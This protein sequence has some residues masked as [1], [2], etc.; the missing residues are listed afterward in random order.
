MR[1]T[2]FPKFGKDLEDLDNYP[3]RLNKVVIKDYE[4]FNAKA[5]S[6]DK[7]FAEE[8]VSSLLNGDA[9]IVKNV[10][11]KDYIKFIFHS[12]GKNLRLQAEPFQP[13]PQSC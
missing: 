12:T 10:F 3:S 13:P 7:K 5:R 2:S 11:S 6:N 4:E 9:Y 8:L 1:T